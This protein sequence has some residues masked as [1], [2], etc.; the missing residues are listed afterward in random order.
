MIASEIKALNFFANGEAGLSQSGKYFDVFDPSTGQVVAQAPQC[1]EDEVNFA[2]ASAHRAFGAWA[3]T[4]AMKRV[5][6]LYKFRDLI[7]KHLDELTRIVCTENGKVWDEAQGDVLKAKEAVELACG[8]P[9]L[10]AG[11]SLM[12]ATSGYD[13][14]LYREPLGVFAGI[15]PFNFPA[16]IPM[17]WMLPLCIATGNTLVLKA[18]SMTPMTSMRMVELLYQAGL[19]KGV[20]NLVTCSRREAEILL[21]HPDVKGIMFVGSTSVGLHVYST[22]AANGKRVQALCEAKNHAL[23]LEDAPLERT[24]RGIINAAFGCA[25]ERCMALPA[26]A[27]QESVADDLVALLVKYARERKIGPA[28]DKTSE[29]GPLVT[30]SHRKFVTGWIEK[31]LAEGAELVLDGRGVVVPGYENGFY[32]GPTIFD[33]VTP[34][35][36]AGDEEIFGPVLCVK[37]VKDFEEGMTL[38]NA[39]RFANGSVIFTQNGHYSREFAR[40][41][42]AGMVGINVGIPVPV[43][44]FPFSGHKNSFFGDLHT[45][46]KDGIRFFTESKCVTAT[47]F[48]EEQMKQ[49]KIDTWD[50]MLGNK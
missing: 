12:N 20:V 4:P 44:V 39:N 26:I 15:A 17:G 36:T 21:K 35:M 5:Q 2:V 28:Y 30:D 23:V 49:E 3:D 43:G 32:L 16:M 29:L 22:A 25:G 40:R 34:G 47:W 10:M 48:D 41:T 50:G 19:P 37:R 7:D 1:T 45:L 31:G 46:G 27:V 38:M 14:V 33:R 6:V 9:S 8:I 24:A 11:E 13:T 42:H 18:A